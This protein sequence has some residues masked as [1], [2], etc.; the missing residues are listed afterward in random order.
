MLVSKF[1]MIWM[2][3][4]AFCEG[5]DV[6]AAVVVVVVGCCCHFSD[7]VVMV[8]LANSTAFEEEKGRLSTEFSNDIVT[9]S[10]V[11]SKPS[12]NISN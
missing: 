5:A 7:V 9:I 3:F 8:F 4:L 10:N 2:C 1:L 6:V 11:N 12:Q